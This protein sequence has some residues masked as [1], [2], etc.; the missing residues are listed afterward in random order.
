[1]SLN[2][3]DFCCRCEGGFAWH[4]NVVRRP[5]TREEGYYDKDGTNRRSTAGYDHPV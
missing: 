1:M 4:L 5:R 2:T 3:L